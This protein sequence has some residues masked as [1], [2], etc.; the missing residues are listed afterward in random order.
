VTET[1]L[2]GFP[3]TF[4]WS[5]DPSS[6]YTAENKLEIGA[7]PMTDLFVEPLGDGVPQLNAPR[8][9]GDLDGD[10]RLQAH[11]RVGFAATYDA[12]ALLVWVDETNWAKLCFER[13]PQGNN[14]VVSVV[15]RGRSDDAN[16]FTVNSDE[17]WLRVSRM[18]HAFAF[19]ASTD[20]SYWDL[21][22][23]FTLWPLPRVA[24]GFVSQSP[25]GTGCTSTFREISW[26]PDRLAGLRD[27]S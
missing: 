6:W 9:L 19:H 26:S 21:V 18:G 1:A 27:G 2:A 12:G 14:M 3:T 10:L 13:S 11:L 23:Y 20:G 15:T 5:A 17:V 16:G 8:L 25:T 22:R 7:G 24:Y 4:R